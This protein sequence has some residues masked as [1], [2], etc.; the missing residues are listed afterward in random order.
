MPQSCLIGS[1]EVDELKSVFLHSGFICCDTLIM[2]MF[3]SNDHALEPQSRFKLHDRYSSFSTHKEQ[4]R[5]RIMR[6]GPPDLG[7]YRVTP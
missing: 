2:K 3:A 7:D 6:T 1:G 4:K 5:F